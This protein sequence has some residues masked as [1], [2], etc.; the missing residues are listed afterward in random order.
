MINTLIVDDDPDIRALLQTVLGLV[1]GFEIV[2][3]ATNGEEAIDLVIELQ[4]ELVL[5]DVLMPVMDG[6]TALPLIKHAARKEVKVVIITALISNSIVSQ[7]N[8]FNLLSQGVRPDLILPKQELLNSID[9]LRML[10]E[11]RG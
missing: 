1:H 6:L 3:E 7:Q 4:P 8:V 11:D 5:L 9:Q 2:G 10:F